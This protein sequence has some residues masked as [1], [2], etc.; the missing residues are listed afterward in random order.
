MSNGRLVDLAQFE[1]VFLVKPSSLGDIVHTL[2]AAHFIK[3]AYPHLRLRW[4]C[5][6]EWAPLLEGNSDLAEVV[7]FP[8]GEFR[9]AAAP[10]KSLFWARRLNAASR[11]LP[12]I[13]LDFQ[14]LL[15]SALISIARGSDPVIGMSDAREGAALLHRATVTVDPGA[16]AVDRYLTLVR[17]LG[18]D[19][20]SSQVAFP[21]PQGSP[22]AG[23]RPP[24]G[25]IV[26]HPFSR[27]KGKSLSNACIQALCDCLAPRPIVI[28]G[29]GQH[30]MAFMGGHISSLLNQTSL[31]E[32][33][34][35]LRQAHGCIS[36]DSGP[37]HIA[38]A[39]NRRTIGIHTWSD[40]RKVG[41]YP[42]SATVWKAGRLAARNAL[43]DE[44]ATTNRP[45][46]AGD[47]RRIAD[48][49]IREWYR[50]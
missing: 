36:V 37:L 15:R 19:A 40:P 9:G 12:E 22:P 30:G 24:A 27:G 4:L 48:F 16:H 47:C 17:A 41:P 6:P 11:E 28:V 42:E 39:V 50:E 23:A 8:R 49:V 29:R 13:T 32:L 1:S 20:P 38:A 14:G 10:I 35:L 45:V 7:L 44:E 21:L 5:N 3:L 43:T 34:W 18:V 33:I 2:P 31:P 26:L 46:E 25:F